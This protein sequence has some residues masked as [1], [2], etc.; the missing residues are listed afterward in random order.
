MQFEELLC[1]FAPAARRPDEVLLVPKLRALREHGK[2]NQQ[3]G[4]DLRE[5]RLHFTTRRSHA[6]LVS[7]KD[8]TTTRGPSQGSPNQSSLFLTVPSNCPYTTASQLR[9]LPSHLLPGDKESPDSGILA[10]IL[11]VNIIRNIYNKRSVFE[12]EPFL[13]FRT[14]RLLS[15]SPLRLKLTTTSPK[16]TATPSP[17]L[18]SPWP[19]EGVVCGCRPSS[20]DFSSSH[21]WTSRR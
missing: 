18:E 17:S 8:Y 21:Q 19:K 12:V 7:H 20:E 13:H 16:G 10:I 2:S 11:L 6:L 9:L 4:L 15:Q 1:C 3:L 5:R 14:S